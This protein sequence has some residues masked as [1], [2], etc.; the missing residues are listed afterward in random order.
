MSRNLDTEAPFQSL[1][2]ISGNAEDFANATS[3]FNFNDASSF[4]APTRSSM[5]FP[6]QPEA[7]SA[8]DSGITEAD[9]AQS[10]TARSRETVTPGVKSQSSA[11]SS[12]ASMFKEF[13]NRQGTTND[14]IYEKCGIVFLGGTSPLTFALEELLQGKL[15]NLHDVGVNMS[16]QSFSQEGLAGPEQN[17]HPLHL[18]PQDIAHRDKKAS[19]RELSTS[20]SGKSNAPLSLRFYPLYSIV[21]KEEFL[22]LYEEQKLPWI[23]LHTVCFVG[24]TFCDQGVIH[25]TGFKKRWH[26]RRL[27]YDRAKILFDIGYETNKI[28]L[29]QTVLM[30]T[31]WG[32]QMKS[33]WNPCSWVGFAVT[34]A[35]SLDIHRLRSSAHMSPKDKG[36]LRR[37]WWT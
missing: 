33:Y 3:Q 22:K 36:L 32:P 4:E 21:N 14:S 30:L 31:F 29:L 24:A 6:C 19:T 9:F 34:I 16:K 18:L 1:E 17:T 20:A 12:L 13:L 28:T 26:T 15:T 5:P 10:E 27:Y 25:K 37:L 35:E 11:T 8:S 7:H 2:G 23:L